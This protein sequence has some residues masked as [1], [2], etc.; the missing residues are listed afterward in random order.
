MTRYRINVNVI[1][2]YNLYVERPEGLTEEQV[3]NSITEEEWLSDEDD[4]YLDPEPPYSVNV[5]GRDYNTLVND[6]DL[7]I[8][9]W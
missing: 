1:T 6:G 8:R 3:C 2:E 4:N 7:T 9:E 5:V